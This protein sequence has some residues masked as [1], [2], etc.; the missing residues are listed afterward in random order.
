MYTK[1]V[2]K[3]KCAI[4]FQRKSSHIVERM[5]SNFRDKLTAILD[6]KDI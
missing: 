4:E 2:K 6:L 5:L 1:K 3:K